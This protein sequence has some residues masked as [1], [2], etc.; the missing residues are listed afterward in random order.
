MP[1]QP[2]SIQI[3][4]NSDSDSQNAIVF[5]QAPEVPADVHV[6]AWLSKACHAGTWVDFNWTVDF[7]FVWGQ[8][9]NLKPGVNYQAGQVVEADLVANNKVTLLYE[10]GGFKFGPTGLGPAHGEG[11][12][13]ISQGPEVPGDGD[14]EQGSVGIGMSGAGTFVVPTDPDGGG[15]IQFTV[16]PIY[17]IAFGQH[18]KGTV[19][20]QDILRFPY[21]LHYP[22]GKFNAIAAFD[23]SAWAVSYR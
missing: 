19:V 12:L 23:G 22:T 13:F 5:Q 1:G 15:G 20:T 9:G 10:G 18:T 17:W 7:N 4:N 2:Y 3:Q 21:A 16:N 8:E 6:L 14:P 11:S